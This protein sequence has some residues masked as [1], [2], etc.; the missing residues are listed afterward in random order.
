MYARSH[1]VI[2]AHLRGNSLAGENLA[3]GARFPHVLRCFAADFTRSRLL[4][5]GG[6]AGV[7]SL[8]ILD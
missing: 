4:E 7:C 1:R 8:H 2:Y 3:V 5:D 6:S